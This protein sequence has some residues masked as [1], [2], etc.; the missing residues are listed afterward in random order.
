M[1]RFVSTYRYDIAIILA[2]FCLPLLLYWDVTL[3]GMTM[4]PIDNLYQWQ[5]WSV[6]AERFGT[7]IPQNSLLSDLIIENYVWKRFSIQS[8]RNGNIPLWNPHIFAGQPF[9]ANGQHSMYYPFSWLFFVLPIHTA[10]GWF[11]LSQLWLAGVSGYVFG[12][13]LTLRRTAAA[14]VGLIYQGSGFLLVSSAIFPMILAAVVW[15]PFLLGCVEMIVRSQRNGRDGQ[16][17]NT[18]PWIVAGSIGVALVTLAGHPEMLIYTLLMMGLYAAWRLFGSLEQSEHQ[19]PITNNRLP[20]TSL[21][22]PA[23]YLLSLVTLGLLLGAIQL[24]PQFELAQTNFREGETTLAIVRD[25]AFPL[26]RVLTFVLPN[27]FGNPAHHSYTDALTGETIQFGLNLWG[28][29]NPHGAFSSNWGIKNYVE[30]GMYLGILPLALA[31]FGVVSRWRK[32][33]TVLHSLS[34]ILRSPTGFFLTLGFFAL[35]FIFGSPLYAILYYGLPFFDQLHSPFRWVFALSIAVAALAGYGMEAFLAGKMGRFGRI[36]SILLLLTGILT[37]VGLF[38]SRIFFAQLEPIINPIFEA[39]AQAPDAFASGRAF[40]SYLFPQVLTLGLITFASGLLLFWGSRQR[41]DNPSSLLLPTAFFLLIILDLFLANRSF[42]VAND[43]ALL[44]FKP[45]MVEW[46]EQQAGQWRI[47]SFAPKDKAFNANSGWLYNIEDVRGYDSIINKQYTTYMEA[48]EPQGE[49]AFNRV[50]PVKDINALNSP[51][52]DLLNVKYIVSSEQ[53]DELPKLSRVWE[54][55]GVQIYENLAAL[56]RAYTLP[57]TAAYRTD[58]VLG[59]VK[60]IDPRTQLL[61]EAP[62]EPE[63]RSVAAAPVAATITSYDNVEVWVDVSVSEASWLVLNDSFADGWK[64]FVRPIGADD[65]AEVELSIER[66]NGNFRAVQL[67]AGDTTVRFRYSPRSFILGGLASLMGGVIIVLSLGVWGWRRVYRQEGELTNT[68]SIAKN[69]VVPMALNLFNKGID[70]SFAMFY[71]RMLGPGESGKY[72]AAISIALWFDI[73]ANW[74]LDAL[75]IRNGS[76]EKEK[77]SSYLLNTTLLRVGTMLIAIVPIALYLG[78]GFLASDPLPRD[79]IMALGLIMV[80]MVFSGVAKSLTGVFYVF[81]SAEYPAA[82]AAVTTILKVAL[83]VMV[84]L[85]GWGFIGLAGVSIVTNIVTLTLLGFIAFRLFPLNGPWTLDR[86]IQREAWR[87]GYPLMINHLLATVFFKIDQTLL[88]QFDTE[89]AVGWYNAAYKWVDGFNVIPSF[90]TFA[91][92]PIIA[93]QVKSN[94]N[95]A[96]RTFRMAV[97]LLVLV[98]LPLAAVI[99]L[100]ADLMIGVVGGEAFLPHGAVS[101]RLVI[102][103]I[104]IGWINSV[105]N[106]MIVSL[107]LEKRLTRGFIV[108]VLFNTIGNLIFIPM[109]S[110]VAAAITTILSELILLIMFN[111]Y[112]RQRMPEVQW[113]KLLWRPLAITVIMVGVMLLGAQLNMWLGLLVGVLAYL[114]G[115]WGFGVFGEEER[116]ILSQILPAR[117]IDRLPI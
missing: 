78:A 45:Q 42:H 7:T 82:L 55:E 63:Q 71:L 92:F 86:E 103:S 100:L 101:L 65:S 113:F 112:L 47:T 19:R 30:G 87:V 43:P 90:F 70:F 8:L 67:E 66:A 110:Y 56:P 5:P 99:T 38:I 40:Y 50:Q 15:L 49:L 88:I 17:G 53:L 21:I 102:W 80:G 29:L 35:N 77:V 79:V 41:I 6:Y 13:I 95:D 59:A 24:L 69:S 97:K 83:G 10:F 114:V 39:I 34:A 98:A 85:L 14:I 33:R 116:H 32:E 54:G 25:W 2:L 11:T 18:L 60:R 62:N 84:L 1:Q 57:L 75:I 23:I 61:L 94:V 109:F 93:R 48:I 26:R 104:P 58:D 9:L 68:Q 74:G 96:R 73:V 12:R 89:E 117:V 44:D 107:G 46:L 64:A 91:L 106:Y 52:L 51:L 37:V 81:E 22:K 72:A 27:F 20:F 108:G 28:N 36:S 4:L 31:L 105:T 76:Q 3:G 111:H 16:G 115:L